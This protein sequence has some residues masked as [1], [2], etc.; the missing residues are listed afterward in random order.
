MRGDNVPEVRNI[1]S[2]PFRR[3][4]QLYS[5]EQERN[6]RTLDSLGSKGEENMI[7]GMLLPTDTSPRSK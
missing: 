2:S 3:H 6:R 7:L 5:F 4:I 1:P